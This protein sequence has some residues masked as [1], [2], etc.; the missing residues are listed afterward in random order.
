MNKLLRHARITVGVVDPEADT[1]LVVS[2]Q[3]FFKSDNFENVIPRNAKDDL[4]ALGGGK[5]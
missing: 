3:V 2:E 4:V 5:P 1:D